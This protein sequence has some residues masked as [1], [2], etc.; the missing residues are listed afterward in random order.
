MTAHSVVFYVIFL[1]QVLLISF[2]LPRKVLSRVSL[3]SG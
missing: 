1:S 3:F 2:Y